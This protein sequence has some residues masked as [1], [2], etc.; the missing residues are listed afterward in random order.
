M[1]ARL[2]LT[3]LV[4]APLA[5]AGCG[6]HEVDLLRHLD[7]GVPVDAETDAYRP[8]TLD[9]GVLPELYCVERINELRTA[10]GLPPYK[11]QSVEEVCVFNQVSLDAQANRQF[12]AFGMCGESM[13]AECPR[14]YGSPRDV[15]A[16]C[17][18]QMWETLPGS[19]QHDALAGNYAAVECGTY[20]TGDGHTWALVDFF[21]P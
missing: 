15:L 16:L 5:A 2:L 17:L 7:A 12:Y 8:I 20:Q 1:S 9:A 18:Q 6:R 10:V 14:Y 19:P 13:A 3:S 11:R 4:L 21:G